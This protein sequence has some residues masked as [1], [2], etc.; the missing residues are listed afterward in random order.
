MTIFGLLFST[1]AYMPSK[2]TRFSPDVSKLQ[3]D[4]VHSVNEK[5]VMTLALEVLFAECSSVA[6][7]ML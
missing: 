4:D 1:A 2:S 3:T 5:G 6:L 7:S